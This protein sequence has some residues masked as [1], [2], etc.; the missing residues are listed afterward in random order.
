MFTEKDKEENFNKN[1]ITKDEILLDF[2]LKKHNVDN[3]IF[4]SVQKMKE[5]SMIQHFT[6]T[7]LSNL[8]FV[9]KISGDYEEYLIVNEKVS[10]INI[11]YKN[12]DTFTRTYQVIDQK[13]IENNGK[14]YLTLKQF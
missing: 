1:S 9:S 3:T 6:Y 5:H 12:I 2:I 13:E 4:T 8:S 10:Q 14:I 11:S 7:T